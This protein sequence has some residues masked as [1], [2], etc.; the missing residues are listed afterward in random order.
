MPENNSEGDRSQQKKRRIPGACDICKKKKSDSGEMP[1]NRCTNC[2]QFG[3]ECTHKE[4]TKTLGPAKGYVESLEARLEKM[5]RLLAKLLPQDVDISKE[6]ERLEEQEAQTNSDKLPR[7]DD[8]VEDMAIQLTSKLNLNPQEHRFFGRSSGFQLIQTA[9]DLKQEY[10]GDILMQK[11]LL[12]SKRREFWDYP[13]WAI[14]KDPMHEPDIVTFIYPDAD[15]MPSLIDAYFEQ[16]NCFLPLL[17]RPT[18]E[19]LVAEGLHY[20]DSMFGSVLLLVCAHGARFSEDPRVLS[21]GTDSPRS[22]GWKWYEQ[23]NAFRR[24][25]IKRTVLYELQM[26]ALHVMFSKTGEAPQGIWAE[27]G[28]GVRLAQEVGAHRKRRRSDS[29]PT[30]E[31]ELWKRAF[32][33]ILSIDRFISAGSGRPCGLQDEDFDLDLPLEVDDEY[34]ENGFKQPADKPS[35]I[36]FFNCYL[37]LMDILAYAMRLIYPV[38]RPKNFFGAATQ[39]SEQQII[40]ELDSTMNNWMDSVPSHL[41]WNPHC[42]D[43]LFLKQSAYLHATYYHLQIFIHRPFIP[44]PRNPAPISFPSLAICTNAARSCCHVLESFTKLSSMPLTELQNIIFTSA[45]ILL[46]NI[47][48]GKR[49]GYAPNPLREMEDVQRCMD[50]LKMTE[51]RCA[52]AG[53]YWDILTEL[54]YAGHMSISMKKSDAIKNGRK[55]NRD[56]AEQTTS[57]ST[58]LPSSSN[59]ARPIAGNRRVSESQSPPS[60]PQTPPETALFSLPMY[61]NELG[62][63][64]VYGQFNFSD[65]LNTYAPPTAN[66]VTNFD[67]FFFNISATNQNNIVQPDLSGL[68]NGT[69]PIFDDKNQPVDNNFVQP[70]QQPPATDITSIFGPSFDADEWARSIPQMDMDT[71]NMWSMAPTNLEYVVAVVA[72]IMKRI[73]VNLSCDYRMDDWNSYISSV[74]QITQA[75]SSSFGTQ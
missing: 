63:L 42:E 31:D 51:R 70:V 54:A 5:D 2:I 27:I 4:V 15:L 47:W 66:Q 37:R 45:V 38:K 22:A 48:S 49:S 75:R 7:N 29:P 8:V 13:S 57:T 12:P 72:T 52:L 20:S 19:K 73:F 14:M 10:T 16:M 23:V 36:T 35:S 33:V 64:P 34:W 74:E 21:K 59:E 25:L 56:A 71:M 55:R 24:T 44:S 9:L 18:F 6:V 11:P 60:V 62:R 50:I 17:H 46:L 58:S 68:A 67:Q 41:R 65:S 53:R 3:L 69:L 26:I 1:G 40:V 43:E 32:W 30:P 39:Y 28:L 61:S